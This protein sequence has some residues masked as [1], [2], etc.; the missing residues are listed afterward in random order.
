M[1]LKNIMSNYLNE[2]SSKFEVENSFKP[3]VSI[4][5]DTWNSNEVSLKKVFKFKEQKHLEYFIV[6]LIKYK[7]ECAADIEVR[8]RKNIVGII[9]HALPNTISEIEIEA[10]QDVDKIKKDVMYYYASEQ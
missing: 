6:E 3:I 8:F 1:Y 2:M 7:K 4:K 5:K 9:I 10:A